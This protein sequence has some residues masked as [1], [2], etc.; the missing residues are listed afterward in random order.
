MLVVPV[1][2]A[3]LA[4]LVVPAVPAVPAVLAVLVVRKPSG[5]LRGSDESLTDVR[6][7]WIPGA[8][9]VLLDG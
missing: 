3:V 4:A 9:G 8:A 1:M 6:R 7:P 2:L 5:A